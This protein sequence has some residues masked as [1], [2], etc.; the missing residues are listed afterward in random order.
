MEIREPDKAQ[1]QSSSAEAE[2]ACQLLRQD[3]SNGLDMLFELYY[4]VLALTAGRLLNDREKAEELASNAF[5][6]LW[7][8]RKEFASS[9]EVK[10]FLFENVLEGC[11]KTAGHSRCATYGREQPFTAL[12]EALLAD[13]LIRSIDAHDR[14][15]GIKTGK[16]DDA[17]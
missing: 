13:F 9:S 14:P 4:P 17:D 2:Q 11:R 15:T 3:D 16:L 7:R 10:A 8:R 12:A 1:G 5:V 6:N